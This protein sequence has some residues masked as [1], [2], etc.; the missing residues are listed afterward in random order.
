MA[1]LLIAMASGKNKKVSV[2]LVTAVLV[3]TKVVPICICLGF[4]VHDC[5]FGNAHPFI[6]VWQVMQKLKNSSGLC[7]RFKVFL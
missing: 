3:H 1:C 7:G 5:H 2:Y 4:A 6:F